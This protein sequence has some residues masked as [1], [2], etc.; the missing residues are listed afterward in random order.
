MV[1]RNCKSGALWRGTGCVKRGSMMGVRWLIAG[2]FGLV[3][4]GGVSLAFYG[5]QATAFWLV[6]SAPK[7]GKTQ[8]LRDRAFGPEPWQKLDIYRRP[9]PA[10]K[11]PVIVFFYGGRW[12]N[13]AKELYAFAGDAFAKRG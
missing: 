7:L 8:I 2:L 12:T 13:G 1:E 9:A 4:F 11:L 3:I 5:V 10:P 6:N